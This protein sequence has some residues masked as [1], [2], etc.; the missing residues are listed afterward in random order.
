LNKRFRWFWAGIITLPPLNI[1][2]P[3]KI[4]PPF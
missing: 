4:K 3:L 1:K 2:P